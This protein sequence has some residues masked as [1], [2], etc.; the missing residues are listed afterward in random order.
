MENKPNNEPV[1]S[2]S[3]PPQPESLTTQSESV[4]DTAADAGIAKATAATRSRRGSYKPNHRATFI[5][6]AVV[7]VILVVNGAI[8]GFVLKGRG[9]EA[10][11]IAEET[12]TLSPATLQGLGINKTPVNNS[13]AELIVG[14]NSRFRGTLT[15]SKD[16]S[17][18]G[19]LKLNSKFTA[20][21][22]ALAK[23]DA[24][25]TSVNQLNI[26]GDATAT[27]L[28]LR[29][30]FTVA[31]A[32]RLQGPVTI[33][34]LT[35]IN[36][37]LNITG[38]VAIGGTLTVRTFQASSLTSDTTL[39]I[40][41]HIVTRG[42]APSVT[43]A[44]GAGPSGTVSISGSDAAGTIAVNAGVGA[45]GGVLASVTFN[46]PYASIPRV[47]VT[48]VGGGLGSVYVNRSAT[49]FSV[50]VNGAMPPGGY[51]FDYFVIQ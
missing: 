10:S 51:A 18:G 47:I 26:N 43:N 29:K 16:V 2:T 33:S 11:R 19:Q 39:T 1:T 27:S 50:G 28:V 45:S 25:D 24:G 49:G 38:S 35:T 3:G 36:N 12:V 31:G 7:V 30:D 9:D 23:L 44:G 6:L 42:S 21:E 5:G 48:T 15:V 37:N 32:T 46:Q 4:G 40:G 20:T 13:A 8:I 34:Q 17:I 22:A 41:G 14:P